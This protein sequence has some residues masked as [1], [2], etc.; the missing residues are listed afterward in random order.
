MNLAQL[1]AEAEQRGLASASAENQN[2]ILPEAKPEVEYSKLP[3]EPQPNAGNSFD[4]V[5]LTQ[6]NAEMDQ[7]RNAQQPD[8]SNYNDIELRRVNEIISNVTGM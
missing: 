2:V 3:K 7:H 8:R 4:E 1:N 5:G 6:L